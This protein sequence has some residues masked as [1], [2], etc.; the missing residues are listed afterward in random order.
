[1]RQP[2]IES[3]T[4]LSGKKILKN[5]RFMTAGRNLVPA[6]ELDIRLAI[7]FKCDTSLFV[8]IGF[9]PEKNRVEI[10]ISSRSGMQHPYL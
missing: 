7:N 1:M 3:V 2:Y 9:S 4:A 10:C 6:M 8:R 5:C